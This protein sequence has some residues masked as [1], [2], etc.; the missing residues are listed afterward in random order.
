MADPSVLESP[1][2]RSSKLVGVTA[3]SE[4]EYCPRVE[5]GW[6]RSLL[7]PQSHSRQQRLLH[8]L[9][10]QIVRQF[11]ELVE[12]G[13]ADLSGRCAAGHHEVDEASDDLAVMVEWDR[14]VLEGL[15]GGYGDKVSNEGA[16]EDVSMLLRKVVIVAYLSF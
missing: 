6:R 4:F 14:S 12:F 5:V 8:L 1:D 13:H 11:E 7:Y 3:S 10:R 2:T 15:I 16:G 9:G